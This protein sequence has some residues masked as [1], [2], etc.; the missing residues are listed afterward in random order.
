MK[1]VLRLGACLT[2]GAALTLSACGSDSN[3]GATGTGGATGGAGGATGGSGGA[4]GG[5]GGAT[6]GSGGSAGAATGGAGGA[7]GAATGGGG[8][9]AGGGSGGAAGGAG[10]DAAAP[11]AEVVDCAAATPDA[12]VTIQGTALTQSFSPANVSVN[13]G[14]VVKWVND[15]QVGHTVTSGVATDANQW[16]E[17]VI[18]TKAQNGAGCLKFLAANTYQYHCSI[19]PTLLGSV[20]VQ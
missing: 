17:L 6:G 7:A 9:M 4:T 10:G 8:G 5:T 14:D 3:D 15:T 2:I 11:V 1:P 18:A 13:V 12:T 16:P 19:H 20:T